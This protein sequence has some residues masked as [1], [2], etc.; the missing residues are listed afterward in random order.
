MRIAWF[1]PLSEKSAIGRVSVAVTAALAK[2]AEVDLWY[3]DPGRV[4]EAQTRTVFFEDGSA[5]K[6]ESLARYNAVIY[7]FGN[8]LPFHREIYLVSRRVPGICVLHD[9]A[10]HHFFAAYYLEDLR[11]PDLYIELMAKWYGEKGQQ[12]A[13]AAVQGVS[14]VWETD[15]VLDYPLFEETLRGACGVVTHSRYSLD[16]ITPVY[17]G[18]STNILLPY[19]IVTPKSVPGRADI[20]VPNDALLLVTVGYV[21]SNKRIESVI[22][23]LAGW[24]TPEKVRYVILGP[25]EEAYRRRLD[26]LIRSHRL[27]DVVHLTGYASEEVLAAHLQAADICVNLR[28][29]ALEGA[30]ASVIE[31]MLYGKPVIV[32]DTGFYRELPDDCVRKINPEQER[33]E[34]SAA[35]KALIADAAMRREM[36][37]RAQAFAE[38]NCRA[39]VYAQQILKF[40][41]QVRA[42]RP[43]IELADRVSA[44]LRRVGVTREMEIV[45]TLGREYQTLFSDQP[46]PHDCASVSHGTPTAFSST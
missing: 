28:Y 33:E 29:P 46:G 17:G 21:N 27:E 1:T 2:Y 39:S 37:C 7:N 14:R 42:A 25:Y 32:S 31:E 18:P 26:R 13:Q 6:P 12:V 20:G 44:E 9:N 40:I 15:D 11:S 19:D 23:A 38:S 41:S 4:R 3:A 16:Q 5:V 10:M 22:E 34:L 30:S 8:H 35:L 36:G 43:M 24:A 45:D